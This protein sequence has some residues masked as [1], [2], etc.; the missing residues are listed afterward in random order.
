ML[1]W[2]KRGFY[3]FFAIFIIYNI[4]LSSTLVRLGEVNLSNDIGRD[5][6]LLQELDQKKIVL[7]GARSNV[8][9]VFHGPLWTY[10]NYPAYLIG[11]G[12]P[13]TVAW[14]WVLFSIIS[15]VTTFIIMKK[16]F[17][18]LA[19]FLTTAMLSV[20]IVPFID[21]MF[22]PY[23][24][25]FF[26][27]AFL[28]SIYKYFLSK[29]PVFLAIHF[30]LAAFLI[31]LNIGSG[32]LLAMLSLG[33]SLGFIVKNKL[34][35]HIFSLFTLPL[36]CINFIIFDLRH[37]F[38]I[39]K[40]LLNL[41]KSSKFIIPFNDWIFQRIDLA[42][43]MQ[44]LL[45]NIVYLS[46]LIFILVML[47][48][49]IKI[50]NKEKH[51]TFFIILA[52]Y[53]FGFMVLSYFNKGALLVDQIFFL[54]PLTIIW[55]GILSVGKYRQLFI[56]IVI[57]VLYLNFNTAKAFVESSSTTIGKIPDSWVSLKNVASSII[58]EERGKQFG[59]FVYA[60]DSFAYQQR[61]AMIFSFKKADLK[62][63][64][65]KKMPVT[66]IVVSP[67][68]VNKPYM[69]EE[70]WIENEA[71]INTKPSE[72]KNFPSGYKIE[73][74]ELSNDEQNVLFDP[75]IKLELNFR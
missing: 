16:L 49:I 1:V 20:Y 41:G 63:F 37:N 72:V 53:Y 61:Y 59:Y 74:F 21:S 75:N 14:G 56:L 62:A 9:G 31:H 40:S 23:A 48:T 19:A 10:L 26:I 28:F 34:W 57:V 45:T 36:F 71:K 58:K 3:L 6:L 2:F 29:R 65:Y 7:I 43:S 17:G 32:I 70:W 50:K 42:V 25:Y 11:K 55:L 24:M 51:R 5:F 54:I 39:T 8:Q 30:M 44:L 73:K 38:L 18:N 33:L 22:G 67:R 52:F 12:D 64:E 13:V 4:F 60:P 47:F 69:S 66:F 46:V 35:I 15:L 27:P 68:P